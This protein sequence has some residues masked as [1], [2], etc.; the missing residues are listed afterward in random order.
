VCPWVDVL[1]F[2]FVIVLCRQLIDKRLELY[3]RD[4][5]YIS[6]LLIDCVCVCVCETQIKNKIT[7]YF[8]HVHSTYT[9][10]GE[11]LLGKK[12]YISLGEKSLR[13]MFLG[14]LSLGKLSL[15]HPCVPQGTI[16][17]CCYCLKCRTCFI[18]R[19][20]KNTTGA[21]SLVSL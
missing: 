13:K 3:P 7:I 5:R 17:Y 19:T 9:C 21:S 4:T 8:L 16:R 14:K 6:F 18:T 1:C 15:G 20:D 10:L 12:F 2:L 11:K